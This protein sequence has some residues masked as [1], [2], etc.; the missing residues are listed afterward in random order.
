MQ[1]LCAHLGLSFCFPLPCGVVVFLAAAAFCS[2]CVSF[3]AIW[4]LSSS[5]FLSLASPSPEHCLWEAGGSC[6]IYLWGRL[7]RFFDVSPRLK[8]DAEV[9]AGSDGTW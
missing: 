5:A 1:E 6:V 2:V 7:K 4:A 9:I 3:V 8:I